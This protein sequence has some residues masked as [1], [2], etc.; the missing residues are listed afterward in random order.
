[1]H[2]ESRLNN[3]M[4]FIHPYCLSLDSIGNALYS[5][6]INNWVQKI[7]ATK[8]EPIIRF[9][10]IQTELDKVLHQLRQYASVLREFNGLSNYITLS[11]L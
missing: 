4:P 8:T 11:K 7:A 1:M 6:V 2:V 9:L 3:S 10:I 5:F